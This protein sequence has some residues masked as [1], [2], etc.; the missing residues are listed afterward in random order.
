MYCNIYAAHL[1]GLRRH[2]KHGRQRAQRREAD[3][4]GLSGVVDC[5]TVGLRCIRQDAGAKAIAEEAQ[6]RQ[7][8]IHNPFGGR[9]RCFG[10]GCH[11]S[12]GVGSSDT[13]TLFI[14]GVMWLQIRW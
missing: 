3:P 5:T 7:H 6:P 11:G 14:D 4:E 13:G 8:A 2:V 12:G 1:H 9:D 10:R